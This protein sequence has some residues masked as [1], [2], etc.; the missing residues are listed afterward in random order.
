MP[1]ILAIV[2]TFSAEG[3]VVRLVGQYRGR[4][5]DLQDRR[6]VIVCWR[7]AGGSFD[8]RLLTDDDYARTNQSFVRASL[9]SI[10]TAPAITG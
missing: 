8:N 3:G 1:P 6:R 9:A 5:G 10:A 2:V 4:Q 7:C